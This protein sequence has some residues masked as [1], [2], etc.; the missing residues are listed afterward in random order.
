LYL[1]LILKEFSGADIKAA[2]DIAIESKLEQAFTDGIPKPLTTKDISKAIKK[3]KSSTKEWFG[4][5]KNYALYSNDGGLYDEILDYLN[6][7]K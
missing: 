7:K 6:I 5:A 1:L 2:I 3:M 4:S